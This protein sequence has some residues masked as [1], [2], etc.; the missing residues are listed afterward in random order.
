VQISHTSHDFDYNLIG[1]FAALNFDAAVRFKVEYV[2]GFSD[3][4]NGYSYFLTI[5]PRVFNQRGTETESKLIQVRH[6]IS[7]S[8]GPY[9]SLYFQI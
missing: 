3:D 9:V 1:T 8:F 7:S 5:Q 4:A 2:A 6:V